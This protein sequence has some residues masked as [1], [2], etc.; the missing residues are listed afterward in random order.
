MKKVGTNRNL[1]YAIRA[2]ELCNSVLYGT[3]S[4]TYVCVTGFSFKMK[5]DLNIRDGN[6][7]KE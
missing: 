1:C 2:A 3:V 7:S 5:I 6:T 4:C